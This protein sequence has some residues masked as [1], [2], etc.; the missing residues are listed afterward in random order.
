MLQ[1]FQHVM[2][3]R[4]VSDVTAVTSQ[5]ASLVRGEGEGRG[6][7][8]GWGCSPQHLILRTLVAHSR[9]LTASVVCSRCCLVGRQAGRQ[10][11]RAWLWLCFGFIHV[12]HPDLH[13]CV[14][15]LAG[16]IELEHCHQQTLC[17]RAREEQGQE[18]E[19]VLHE[20]PGSGSS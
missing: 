9:R 8:E 15:A 2:C 20:L 6:G 10:A 4:A 13:C 5:G 11:G 12:H 3:E 19:H 7:G 14:G 16:M 1:L 18:H 17:S